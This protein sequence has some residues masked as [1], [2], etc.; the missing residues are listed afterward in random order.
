VGGEVFADLALEVMFPVKI[1][2][3]L[4]LPWKKSRRT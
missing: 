3:P 2:P 1:H 4:S